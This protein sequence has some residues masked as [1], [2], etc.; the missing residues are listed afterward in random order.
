MPAIKFLSP[1]LIFIFFTINVSSDTKIGFGSPNK[2]G[3][4]SVHGAPLG[5][6]E[7]SLARQKLKW[8]FKPFVIPKEFMTNGI[9]KLKAL[10][11]KKT[12]TKC[13][14]YIRKNIQNNLANCKGEK[15]HV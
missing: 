7:L 9:V 10:D 8:N 2:Q 13:S 5:D 3:T 14:I 12:G 4:A 11:L 15:N 6:E 1:F